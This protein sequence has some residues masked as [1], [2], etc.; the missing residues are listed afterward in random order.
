MSRCATALW[1][2]P[3]VKNIPSVVES[4][5]A[6]GRQQAQGAKRLANPTARTGTVEPSNEGGAVNT[7][8]WRW[9]HPAEHV[10]IIAMGVAA[11]PCRRSE[12]V[13]T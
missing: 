4:S 10:T 2:T 3:H 11:A 9:K 12:E 8:M 13:R 5:L 1:V 7:T 6:P